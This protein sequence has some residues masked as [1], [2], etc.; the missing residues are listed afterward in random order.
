MSGVAAS[1][2][3]RA[4]I[5]LL[6]LLAAFAARAD[7]PWVARGADG[8]PEIRFYFFWSLTCP[9][10]TEAHPHIT[11]LPKERPWLRLHELE[12]SRNPDNARR[13]EEIVAQAGMEEQAG[14]PAFLFC[15]EMHFGWDS[16]AGMGAML[17]ARLDDRL[18]RVIS[19][20][21]KL[22]ANAATARPD[23]H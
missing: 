1:S 6:L 10:C 22:S 16:A 15:G 11:A 4:I 2:I 13:F 12:L 17:Q 23:T 14:V 20:N 9:H 3:T 19:E 5:P 8:Q 7:D 21:V 18:M